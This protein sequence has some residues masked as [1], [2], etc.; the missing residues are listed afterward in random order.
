MAG[1]EQKIIDVKI[2]GV[3]DLLKLKR[4]LKSLKKEQSEVQKVNKAQEKSWID[5]ERAITKATKK[6]K[7]SRLEITKLNKEQ[8]KSGKG[9]AGF[10]KNMLKTAV[11]ITAVVTAIRFLSR[12]FTTVA[13][14]F[15]EFE[16]VMAKVNA[17][18]GA[19]AEE[20]KA[21]TAT[22]EELGRTTFF[23]AE[24]VGQLQL[25]YSKLGFTA[26]E[27]Q[28]AVKPTL[29]LATATGTDLARAAQVAGA[30]V[31]GFGLDA[32]ETERVVDVMAVAFASSAMDIEKWQTSMT[33][34]AP[35]AK[36]AGFSIEDTAAMM[37]K[38]TDSGIEASIAGTS[39]R[40]ILLKMQDPS[41]ELSMRFGR[42]I[43]S[44]DDLVPAMQKFVKEGGKMKDVMEVVD[45][46]QAAAFEQLI[47]TAGGTLE[48][49]DAL[50]A[51][52]GEGARMA[53][54]V[55]DTMQGAFLKFKS[56]LQGLSISLMK[57]YAPAL[58][59]VMER[60]AKFFNA[61]AGEKNIHKL[62]TFLKVLKN[63]V[64]T[65]GA[66]KIGIVAI[67]AAQYIATKVTAAW[68][69]I[70]L[71]AKL[72]TDAMTASM[73][74]LRAAIARTGVGL[75]VLALADLIISMATFNKEAR[76]ATDWTEKLKGGIKDE[77]KSV[78]A[79]EVAL[80]RLIKAK[81][82]IDKYSKDEVKNLDKAS[83][84]YAQYAKQLVIAT[85]ST[86]TLNTAFTENG[87][88]LI[89]LQTDIEDTQKKFS[90]LAEQMRN[91]AAISVAAQMSADI[92]KTKM[93]V[94]NLMSE[95]VA[96]VSKT[97]GREITEAT[98][99]DLMKDIAD[100]G[101]FETW[102]GKM[103][104]GL[105]SFF[106]GSKTAF[107][108]VKE[109]IDESGVSM[110]DFIKYAEKGKWYHGE[111]TG[112]AMMN[113]DLDAINAE[114]K[115]LFPNFENFI[116][117][118]G[119]M[120]EDDGGDNTVVNWANEMIEALNKVKEARRDN[121]ISDQQ[122]NEQMLSEKKRI[123]QR[124]LDETKTTA[125]R[126]L[127]IK[128]QIIGIELQEKKALKESNITALNEE[129]QA[130]KDILAQEVRDGKHSKLSEKAELLRIE[131]EHLEDM[132]SLN[133]GYV[134]DLETTNK[135]ITENEQQVLDLKKE[136]QLEAAQFGLDLATEMASAT[137]QIMKNN[138]AREKAAAEQSISDKYNWELQVLDR[139]LADKE[140]SQ[141]TYNGKKL[142]AEGEQNAAELELKKEMAE[143][144]RNIA[145][146]EA[147]INTAQAIVAAWISPYTAPFIIPFILASTAAQLAVIASTQFSKGGMIEE[148]AGGG[149]VHGKSHAQGGEKFAVGGRVVELEG[150]EAVINKRSAS[151]FRG[152]LSAMNS[153]GGGVKF[154]DGGLLNSGSFNAV[155]FNAS[156][157]NQPGGTT[158]VV[159][160]ES[161]IT[162]SQSKVRAIQSNASF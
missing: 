156:Q 69:V 121:V 108:E 149:M 146:A 30:A 41:S 155:K 126:E 151:M 73:V 77:E 38:L 76:E 134:K 71:K 136:Q 29:D 74:R 105:N 68:A 43:H 113:K 32:S 107:V 52:N 142:I 87:Q 17:V 37:S 2:K 78:D 152:Q 158:K 143:K 47:T 117:L 11:S 66:Y 59:K 139:Q 84:E 161:D 31:R 160:V 104:Q 19:T 40:N 1:R 35:I 67:S 50:L 82:T 110:G 95:L 75:L 119:K 13:T 14:T 46:R 147:L 140:I 138:L 21:L 42:T 10:S 44:L 99:L 61:V 24:Q 80:N 101:S 25:A 22:A 39:L 132:K 15:S 72:N 112:T 56:A 122:F 6:I 115:E 130:K 109:A 131:A 23:T 162:N 54:I 26:K 118:V 48:L 141:A 57:N 144:A 97:L 145:Y 81:E 86:N 85:Q 64:I 90:N 102:L 137:F 18:S 124:E 88:E 60:T 157:F 55:G 154:A 36:S 94:D 111:E 65:L 83:L 89:D 114:L 8:K 16:F 96:T 63:I 45:L 125:S 58:Q 127:Q 106:G 148:F 98:V 159:V 129:T 53:G 49:R 27:M 4:E 135:K 100:D 79:L 34:V 91:T 5:K 12:L 133:K 120:D 116:K 103:S 93:E 128:Q 20:F 123:L 3:N 70:T 9:A 92:I 150:G 62:V 33:K 7:Q 28:D 51:A 153:A